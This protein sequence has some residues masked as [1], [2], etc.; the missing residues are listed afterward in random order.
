MEKLYGPRT[1]CR[2]PRQGQD[3]DVVLL[4]EGAG[5]FYDG[6]GRAV[7]DLAAALEAEELALVVLRFDHAVGQQGQRGVGFEM[8]RGVAVGRTGSDAERQAVVDDELFSV[9]V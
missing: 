7:G 3:R 9:G 6:G 5:G 4:A 2:V 1:S 8:Q